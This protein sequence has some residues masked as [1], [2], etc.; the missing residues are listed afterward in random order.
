MISKSVDASSQD[1]QTRID[2]SG[3]VH[4]R[5]RF[6][7]PLTAREIN[8]R[9]REGLAVDLEDGVR[10]RAAF[11]GPC[12]ALTAVFNVQFYHGLDRL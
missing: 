8:N 7:E 5:A 11:I 9:H 1:E 10:A 3:L 4:V 6:V 2:R 12:I